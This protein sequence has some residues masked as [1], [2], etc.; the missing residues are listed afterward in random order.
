VTDFH[1]GAVLPFLCWRR[2]CPFFA[3]FH[4]RPELL[5]LNGRHHESLNPIV[6]K[7][8]AAPRQLR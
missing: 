3:P 4:D 7:F 6:A 8:V 2:N 1:Q 5:E